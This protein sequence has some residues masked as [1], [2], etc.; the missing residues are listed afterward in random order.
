MIVWH[1]CLRLSEAWSVAH[2]SRDRQTLS[3][4]RQR[5][6]EALKFFDAAKF[7]R[8]L[9]DYFVVAV[10]NNGTTDGLEPRRRLGEQIAC[11]RLDNVFRP[12]SAIGSL[13]VATIN[14]FAG[15]IV[16]KHDGGVAEFICR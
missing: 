5:C 12:Q 14:P 6:D 15:S 10:E 13:A 4:I 8:R 7:D 3:P 16:L 2:L 9:G 1:R 11:D